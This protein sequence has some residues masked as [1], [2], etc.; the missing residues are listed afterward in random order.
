MRLGK[1]DLK[2]RQRLVVKLKV[3]VLVC[4]FSPFF[5]AQDAHHEHPVFN[6][7]YHH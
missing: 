7:T 1:L 6:V 2:L 3:S 4:L 5:C